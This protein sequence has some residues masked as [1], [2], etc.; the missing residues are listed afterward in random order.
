MLSVKQLS[1]RFK[2][3]QALQQINLELTAGIYGLVGP[4]GAGKSTL[5]RILADIILPIEGQV[6]FNNHDITTLGMSYREKLGYL[7]QEFNGYTHFTAEEFLRYVANLKGLTKSE[8]QVR[9]AEL[10][11]LVGLDDV[12]KRKLKG[13][14]GGMKRRVGIAQALLNDPSVLILDEP[15]AGLDPNE[16]IRLRGILSKLAKDKVIILSTH[17]ISD[18]ESIADEVILLKEGKIIQKECPKT[19]IESLRNQVWSFIIPEG[20]LAYYVEKYPIINMHQQQS[21]V[22]LRCI[23]KQQ[24]HSKAVNVEPR[25]EDMYVYHFEQS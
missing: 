18:V 16:R 10:L 9:V 20:E 25:L 14:S 2:H 4:N 19:M 12:K 13:Y 8:E 3:V 6:L 15:T 7:P 1:H 11:E 24:P 5:M 21:R 23:A 22:E 17:I